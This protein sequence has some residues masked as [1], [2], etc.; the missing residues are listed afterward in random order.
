MILK[1]QSFFLLWFTDFRIEKEIC[2]LQNKRNKTSIYILEAETNN[3]GSY[4]SPLHFF[5]LSQCNV[6]C[7]IQIV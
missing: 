3:L 6:D 1:D 4:K 5:L 2:N 7:I